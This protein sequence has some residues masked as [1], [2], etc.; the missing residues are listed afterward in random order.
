I[1]GSAIQSCSRFT[2]S[3]C[4]VAISFLTAAQSSAARAPVVPRRVIDV[5]NAKNVVAAVVRPGIRA[6]GISA[7]R[8]ERPCVER[9]QVYA[10][11]RVSLQHASRRAASVNPLR[12]PAQLSRLAQRGRNPTR[13][14]LGVVPFVGLAAAPA[15][16]AA[17]AFK[18][19][20]S[21]IKPGALLTEQQVFNGFGCDGKNVSPA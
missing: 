11:T 21:A 9:R 17:P 10:G 20:S 7:G 14:P 5:A 4:W 16:A 2:A 13:P 15:M 19:E 18:L 6:M 1:D 8:G 12:G 3:S